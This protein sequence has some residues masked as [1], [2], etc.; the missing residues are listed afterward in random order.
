MCPFLVAKSGSR[1]SFT[2]PMAI[3]LKLVSDVKG[4]QPNFGSPG[5]RQNL[6]LL[7]GI[8]LSF[9]DIVQGESSRLMWEPGNTPA[10]FMCSEFAYALNSS[11][12]YLAFFLLATSYCLWEL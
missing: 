9:C 1:D 8:P 2:S 12:D 3:E 6:I 11:S 7:Q 4:Y 10:G 5:K